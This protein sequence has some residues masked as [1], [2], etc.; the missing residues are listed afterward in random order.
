MKR[1]I[2]AVVIIIVMLAGVLA[3][4]GNLH[5]VFFPSASRILGIARL[6]SAVTTDQS[7]YPHGQPVEITFEVTNPGNRP[8][9]LDFTG[10][11]GFEVVIRNSSGIRVWRL[12]SDPDDLRD[13]TTIELG[14]NETQKFQI[15]WDQKDYHGLPVPPGIYWIR[16][17]LIPANNVGCASSTQVR[18]MPAGASDASIRD[19]QNSGCKEDSGRGAEEEREEF[20]ADYR[21][22]LL[23][24]VHRNAVYN[25][26][27]EEITVT[28]NMADGII[29]IFEEE[30][31]DGDGCRCLCRYDITAT[32][33]GLSPGAYTIRFYNRKTGRFLGE[34]PAVV[35]PW[36]SPLSLPAF[37]L[38]SE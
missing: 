24:L 15:P 28:L 13:L 7:V 16:A 19:Y 2:L 30:K 25:C 36:M 38:M 26:C 33:A 1:H 11:R 35:I 20:A 14:P 5:A 10:G 4:S 34:I 18:I 32:I 27:L 29:W 8:V 22:R 31:L 12:S 23:Y 17:V 21:D 3:G 9:T 37:D 6:H